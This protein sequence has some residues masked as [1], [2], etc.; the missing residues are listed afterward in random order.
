MG[1]FGCPQLNMVSQPVKPL[2]QLSGLL[3]WYV[4]MY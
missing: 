1:E 3:D 2:A 4:K